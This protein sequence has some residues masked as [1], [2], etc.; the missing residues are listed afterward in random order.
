VGDVL[1]AAVVLARDS[2]IDAESALRGWA[3]RYRS[4]FQRME[5][6]ARDRGVDLHALEPAA[7]DALWTAAAAAGAEDTP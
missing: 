6:L 1:A 7:V 5:G 4:R 3:G 2:G